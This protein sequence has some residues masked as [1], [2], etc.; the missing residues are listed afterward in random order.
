MDQEGASKRKGHKPVATPASD[1]LREHDVAATP[2]TRQAHQG[3]TPVLQTPTTPQECA[4]MVQAVEQAIQHAQDATPDSGV[5]AVGRV[6]HLQ[7]WL[8]TAG[9]Q[10]PTPAAKELHRLA[11]AAEDSKRLRKQLEALREAELE[12]AARE[13]EENERGFAMLEEENFS[14]VAQNAELQERLAAAQA[15]RAAAAAQTDA[16]GSPR[17]PASNPASTP[18]SQQWVNGVQARAAVALQRAADTSRLSGAFEEQQLASIKKLDQ[19][20]EQL[21]AM[22]AQRP[23]SSSAQQAAVQ[24]RLLQAEE[25]VHAAAAAAQHATQQLQ[26]MAAEKEQVQQELQAIRQQLETLPVA[27]QQADLHNKLMEAHQQLQQEKQQHQRLTGSLLEHAGRLSHKYASLADD[28]GDLRRRYHHLASTNEQL[29]SQLKEA[30]EALYDVQAVVQATPPAKR[31]QQ[32]QLME[33]VADA[34]QRP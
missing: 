16:A 18:A 15:A 23:G 27:Q 33:R 4:T 26:L 34:E 30:H 13:A 19:A 25:E 11:A 7:E 17:T 2:A 3:R 9:V 6:P 32:R 22:K 14:L 31:Q 5:H 20:K 21:T 24:Q 29:A 12:L 10:L 28:Y 8:D 1:V